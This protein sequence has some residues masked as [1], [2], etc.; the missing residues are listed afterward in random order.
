MRAHAALVR[1]LLVLIHA[2]YDACRKRECHCSFSIRCDVC[3]RPSR[4][5]R[6]PPSRGA[7]Y[8]GTARVDDEGYA[9]SPFHARPSFRS[10][11]CCDASPYPYQR[12]SR[13]RAA[14][15]ALSKLASQGTVCPARRGAARL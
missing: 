5:H 14:R 10:P 4:A 3:M 12:A 2:R 9:A 11:A 6:L 15:R 13:L 8:E 7:V 1:G